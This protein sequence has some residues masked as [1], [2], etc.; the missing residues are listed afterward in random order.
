MRIVI[1]IEG[2]RVI[3]ATVE[4][5]TSAD[6]PPPQ[7]LEAARARG[8]ISAGRA[9]LNPTGMVGPAAAAALQEAGVARGLAG[10]PSS[11]KE[12][13]RATRRRQAGR[14]TRATRARR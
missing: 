9:P 6:G 7:V 10:A 11:T 1:E 3:S 14:S 4:D 2:D 12:K 13:E 5:S 8:A